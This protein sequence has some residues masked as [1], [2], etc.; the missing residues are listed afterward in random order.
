MTVKEIL[1]LDVTVIRHNVRAPVLLFWLG[2][3]HR[4]RWWSLRRSPDPLA[5]F[6][7][8]TAKRTEGRGGEGKKGKGWEG[9]RRA[10]IYFRVI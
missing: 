10:T 1:K 8:A 6:K 9:R 5:G 4:P 2:L 7:E 3:S